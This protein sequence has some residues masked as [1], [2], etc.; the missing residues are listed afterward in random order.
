MKWP[1]RKIRD[2]NQKFKILKGLWNTSYG[3]NK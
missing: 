1:K 3:K 2:L